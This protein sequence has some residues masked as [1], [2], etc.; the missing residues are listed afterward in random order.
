MRWNGQIETRVHESAER[1]SKLLTSWHNSTE[2]TRTK[3]EIAPL[4]MPKTCKSSPIPGKNQAK[5]EKR[6][7]RSRLLL[8]L[9]VKN[10]Y[11][12]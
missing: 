3:I 4:Y 1:I 12:L 7:L 10:D 8:A 11:F 5:T 2:R 6:P 9:F